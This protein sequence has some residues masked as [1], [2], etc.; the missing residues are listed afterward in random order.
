MRVFSYET[1]Q[2]GRENMG[3]LLI[4]GNRSHLAMM[5]MT[6]TM[7]S[8]SRTPSFSYW[9]C[10]HGGN[11]TPQMLANGIDMRAYYV[12][13]GGEWMDALFSLVSCPSY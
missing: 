6:T 9:Q 10:V 1:A 3:G 2:L 8:R 7:S 13:R 11:I 4:R 12:D 5:M